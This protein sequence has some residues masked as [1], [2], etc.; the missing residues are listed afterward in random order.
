M[1]LCRPF[2]SAGDHIAIDL[3]GARAVFTTRHGGVSAGPYESLNLGRMTDDDPA[4]VEANR[5]ALARQ[6]GVEFSHGRQVHGAVVRRVSERRSSAPY[7][8]D[9]TATDVRGIA[10]LVTTADCLPITIAARG[11]V[12]SVH[13]G[14]R[15]LEAG[16]I[17]EGIRA[18]RELGGEG[19]IEAAI[20]P[21]AG[22]CCYEVG[23]E[24]QERFRTFGP[25]VRS[26]D[27][28]DLKRI[29]RLQ[30]ERAGAAR[31]HDAGLCTMCCPDFFSHRRDRGVTGRQAGVAWLT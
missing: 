16:I 12:A 22:P 14:W 3:P 25:E 8:A 21:G 30:L 1:K 9:G 23:E 24:V 18:V 17:A 26:G 31:I 5:A 7:E 28:L 20:G 4:A 13:A 11:A 6:L 29:A 15:G 27:N 2:E 10:P 19:P